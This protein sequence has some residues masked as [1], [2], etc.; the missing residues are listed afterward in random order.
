MGAGEF[1]QLQGEVVFVF[2]FVLSDAS[3]VRHECVTGRIVCWEHRH[4]V[5]EQRGEEHF[6]LATE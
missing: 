1:E 6:E 4:T 3:R 5:L 2:E